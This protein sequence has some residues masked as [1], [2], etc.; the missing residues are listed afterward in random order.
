MRHSELGC[1]VHIGVPVAI[2][3]FTAHFLPPI[4]SQRQRRRGEILNIRV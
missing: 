4:L 2:Q 1:G 3:T